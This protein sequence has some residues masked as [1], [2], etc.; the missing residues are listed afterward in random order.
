MTLDLG[1]SYKIAN[2]SIVVLPGL[3]DLSSND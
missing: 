3:E 2:M 1:S